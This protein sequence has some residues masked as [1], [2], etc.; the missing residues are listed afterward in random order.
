LL[1]KISFCMRRFDLVMLAGAK[2]LQFEE[3][4]FLRS[5][6]ASIEAKD[7]ADKLTIL[8]SPF[9]AAEDHVLSEQALDIRKKSWAPLH[10]F[11]PANPS[12]HVIFEKVNKA[13]GRYL[14]NGDLVFI[15]R[16]STNSG[17]AGYWSSGDRY[18]SYPSPAE[19]DESGSSWMYQGEE[20]DGEGGSD[21]G[22]DATAGGA[23]FGGMFE[24][25][26]EWVWVPNS[27]RAFKFR[28]ELTG[29]SKPGLCLNAKREEEEDFDIG[30]DLF[31]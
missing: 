13:S 28:I 4:F 18:L 22:E 19:E 5:D 29:E 10:G 23:A 14:F 7:L 2:A 16:K 24:D 15:V 3:V 21:G 17:S 1:L 25:K 30:I 26:P 31:G 8:K 6:P 12:D 11:P 27:K 9:V 20:G